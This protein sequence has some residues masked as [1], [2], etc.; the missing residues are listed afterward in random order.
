MSI[1]FIMHFR[2]YICKNLTN[3]DELIN[4]GRNYKLLSNTSLIEENTQQIENTQFSR[5]KHSKYSCVSE[6][7]LSTIFFNSFEDMSAWPCK[8]TKKLYENLWRQH[9]LPIHHSKAQTLAPV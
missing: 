9:D 6:W 8:K 5:Y 1:L 4:L 7:N 2:V 3:Y